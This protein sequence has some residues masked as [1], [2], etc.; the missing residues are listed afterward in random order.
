MLKNFFLF[1]F[2]DC[3]AVEL[4]KSFDSGEIHL[5]SYND[6]ANDTN[7]YNENTADTSGSVPVTSPNSRA[8]FEEL[9]ASRSENHKLHIG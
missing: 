1:A 3:A 9:E 5:L 2:F 6:E 8:M 7:E 4:L